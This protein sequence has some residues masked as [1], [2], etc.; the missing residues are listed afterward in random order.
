MPLPAALIFDFDGLIADTESPVFESWSALYSSVGFDLAKADWVGCVGSDWSSF[1]PIGNLETL[2]GKTLPWKELEAA[3]LKHEESHLESLAPLHGILDLLAEANSA[4][5]PC[6]IA[7]SSPLVWVSRWVTEFGIAD[8]FE[9]IRTKNDVESVKPAPDLF[10]QAASGLGI[11][12]SNCLVL[13]D[14]LNGLR[15]AQAANARCAIIPNPVTRILEFPGADLRFDTLAGVG[16]KELGGA[17][18]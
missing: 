1:D 8:R 18:E 12:P 17:F 14:S 13:E 3:R 2:A 6:A 7:S 9:L 16:L 10:L 4:G 5:V 15:A 11:E